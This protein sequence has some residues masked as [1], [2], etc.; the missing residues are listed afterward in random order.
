VQKSKEA[1]ATNLLY[2]LQSRQLPHMYRFST[3]FWAS[4]GGTGAADRRKDM[5]RE[6][7]AFFSTTPYHGAATDLTTT[8]GRS[9]HLLFL[10][11]ETW[12]D[13]LLVYSAPE[14]DRAPEA[15]EIFRVL[16]CTSTYL[17]DF[18]FSF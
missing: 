7:G 2:I 10:K 1:R 18:A 14:P 9:M 6:S 16:F 5:D 17:M 4:L 12:C 8:H 13:T 11:R 3:P 15:I